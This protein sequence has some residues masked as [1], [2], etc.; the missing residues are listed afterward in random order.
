MKS[1]IDFKEVYD[2]FQIRILNYLSR[3]TGHHDDAE[4]MTQEVF[5]KVSR[6]LSDFNEESKLS[7]WLF[8][9]ATNTA[10]DRS[11]SSTNKHLSNQ[12]SLEDIVGTDE[13]NVQDIHN[14]ALIDQKVIRKDMSVCVREFINNLPTDYKTVIILSELEG[15][16]NKEIADILQ[17]SLATVK[18]RL[19]RARFKLKKILDAECEF[20]KDERNILV[21]DRKPVSE[22]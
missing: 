18:I 13:S 3:L 1:E 5:E 20:Y 19:H 2:E 15:F 22:P 21:C 17:V 7:T 6:S 14:E 4:D 8:R 11:R 9:I 10:I 16:E 12:T